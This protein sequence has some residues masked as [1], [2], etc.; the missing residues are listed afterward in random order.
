MLTMRPMKRKKTV[1]MPY[2]QVFF[3]AIKYV[4]YIAGAIKVVFRVCSFLPLE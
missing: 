2:A 4:F 1:R 3:I